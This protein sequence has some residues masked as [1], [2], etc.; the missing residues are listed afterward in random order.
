LGQAN[1]SNGTP[2]ACPEKLN[3][4]LDYFGRTVNL[5]ARVQ[6]L[7]MENEIYLSD[8]MYRLPGAADLLAAMTAKRRWFTSKASSARSQ[9][10]RCASDKRARRDTMPQR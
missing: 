9:F 8:E 3:E 5:A 2:L 10:T 1:G 6:G 7:A 4:R